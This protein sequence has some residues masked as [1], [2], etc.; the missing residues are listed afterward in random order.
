M[1]DARVMMQKVG[2]T[3]EALEKD[4][5]RTLWHIN[6]ASLAAEKGINSTMSE[7]SALQ[8]RFQQLIND[9]SEAASSFSVLADTLQ[10]KP[11][12]LILGK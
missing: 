1:I 4:V 3:T 10:R 9:L 7:D 2:K 12:A 11:N 8:Y 5:S 6:K